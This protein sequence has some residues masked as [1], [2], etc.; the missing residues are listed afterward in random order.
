MNYTFESGY[1]VFEKKINV[2]FDQLQRPLR[3]AIA[4][5]GGPDSMLLLHYSFLYKEKNS[6]KIDFLLVI[7]IIDGHQLIEPFL[8]K[9][10]EQARDLV[11]AESNFFSINYILYENFDVE[12]FHQKISIEALCHD[13]RKEFFQKA[14]CNFQLDR[15]LTGHT[16]TDQLEH[17]FIGI[18]RYSSLQRISG[19]KEDSGVYKRP[20]LFMKKQNTQEILD[21]NNKKYVLDPCNENKEYLRNAI[22]DALLPVLAKIDVRFEGGIIAMMDQIDQRECF[23]N[24]LVLFE[25][26]KNDFI[27]IS[28]FLTLHAIIQYKII[29]KI[30]YQLSNKKV[31]S[32]AICIEIVRFLNTKQGGK[33]LV[34]SMIIIKKNN[35]WSI[36]I[37]K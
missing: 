4:C 11:V 23:I 29:E 14:I 24:Q 22:R 26:K 37:K 31:V 34:N 3:L 32:L 18:I 17:F 36:E 27:K 5:S 1:L 6:N 28:Y 16:L 9:T 30:I 19:M 13:I 33:H 15:I 20:L 7:H 10:M 35:Y 2:L 8:N 21:K 12:K 25:I